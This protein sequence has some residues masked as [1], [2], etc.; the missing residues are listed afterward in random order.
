MLHL[1]DVAFPDKLVEQ[2]IVLL[3]IAQLLSGT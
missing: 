2:Y 3:Y 1:I